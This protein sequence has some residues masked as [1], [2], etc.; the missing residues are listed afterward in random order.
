MWSAWK[1]GT[2]KSASAAISFAAYRVLLWEASFNSNLSRTFALLTK[3]LRALCYSP[4][5]TSKDG[6]SPAAL[7]NRIA[8]AAIAAGR[9]DGSNEALHYADPTFTSRNQPL[10]VRAD[11]STVED[12]TFWQ[13][14]AL[15]TKSPS[16][17]SVP[18]DVQNFVG[19]QWGRVRS[20]ALGDS[21]IG[22]ETSPLG[23]PSEAAYKR[24]AV[25]VLRATSATGSA[26][27]LW[28]PLDWASL[29]ARNAPAD[30]ARDI[31]L[32]L[33]LGAALN[34][35]AVATWRAKRASEAP[36]PISMIRYLAFQGQS[37][38]RTKPDYSADG[39]PLVPGLIELRGGNVQVLS[40]GRWIDGAAWSPPVATPPSPGGVAEGTAF[41]AAAGRVLTPLIGRPFA[42]QVRAAYTAPFADGVDVPSD[43]IAGGRLGE[44][45][46]TLVLRKLR[47]YR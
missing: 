38:D 13:P 35:T 2:P 9:H 20:F 21:R 30:L 46:A 17:T 19:A 23:D 33:G 28:S 1:A 8:A 31:R 39:L 7:G 47:A 6:G 14:L 24:A 25:A 29:A 3:Q 18:T 43:V 41:A 12:A 16:L 11:D 32:Y 34:D 42:S 22:R 36:R 27:R 5:F 4:D 15:G 40:R 37:S 45:V 44:H 10:I 26:P